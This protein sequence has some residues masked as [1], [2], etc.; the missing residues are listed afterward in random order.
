MLQWSPTQSFRKH[1]IHKE[2]IAGFSRDA[3]RAYAEYFWHGA[4]HIARLEYGPLLQ[5][6]I[7][8]GEDNVKHLISKGV[9]STKRVQMGDFLRHHFENIMNPKPDFHQIRSLAFLWYLG[10][11][12]KSAVVNLTQVPMVTASFLSAQFGTLPT[13]AAI[14]KQYTR[15]QA[16]YRSP[17]KA[18]AMMKDPFESAALDQAITEGIQ[19]ESFA[20]ELAGLAEGGNLNTHR[21]GG[22]V[23]KGLS[24]LYTWAGFAFKTAEML[25]RRV[26]FL[27]ALDLARSNPS[28]DYLKTIQT[29]YNLELQDLINNKQWTLEQATAYLAAK[30]AVRSTQ[31]EYASWARPRLMEG[32]KSAFFT[33]F[34]FA[35]NMMWFMQNSP[36]R[37]RYLLT[38][39]GTAGLMGFAIPIGAG[40]TLGADDLFE[41]VKFTGRWIFGKDW[42]LEKEIREQIVELT[43]MPPDLFLHG[44]SRYG[45]GLE[46]LGDM[47]GLPLPAVDLSGTLGMGSPLPIVSPLVQTL[48]RQGDFND[49]LARFTS[50][51]AGAG[52]GIGIG[53][54]KALSD[55]DTNPR[56]WEQALPTSVANVSKAYRQ[57]KEGAE[58]MRG[59]A[60]L[61]EF[62]RNDPEHMAELAAHSLG[63]RLTRSGQAWDLRIAQLEASAFWDMRRSHLLSQYDLAR[64]GGVT[65]EV[66]DMLEDIKRYNKQ[67][68]FPEL[69]ISRDTLSR[70]IKMR[71]ISRA[72]RSA[73]MPDA[74]YLTGVYEEL[75]RLHPESQRISVGQEPAR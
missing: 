19:D 64:Q 55:E 38:L 48:G 40:V 30:D 72:R 45:F 67:V 47:T 73:G 35:Q 7:K 1:F 12:V 39:L 49:K 69:A 63:F 6:A 74:K 4:N 51:G 46:H 70:S 61:I 20:M 23:H 53:I 65:A 33:F 10:F 66:N 18:A 9:N 17:K 56:R 37:T 75:E 13:T 44:V 50:E 21:M 24:H 22:A 57:W 16:T 43:D 68:P 42:N 34:M 5:D 25:N 41:L 11:N 14:S 71:E 58:K 15:L 62:D 31:F 32:K 3:L 8:H 29:Q 52:F 26:T 60:E 54:L 59:G 27:A 36:G 28:A 2:N